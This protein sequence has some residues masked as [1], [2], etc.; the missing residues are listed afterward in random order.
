MRTI[1]VSDTVRVLIT[2]VEN[3]VMSWTARYLLEEGF[4]IRAVVDR[5]VCSDYTTTT[6][7]MEELK[8]KFEGRLETVHT[9][10]VNED[11]LLLNSVMEDCG[12]IIH[13]ADYGNPKTVQEST[14]LMKKLI[15]V[16]HTTPTIKRFI[17]CCSDCCLYNNPKDLS[18]H[19]WTEENFTEDISNNFSAAAEQFAWVYW[20]SLEDISQPS[21]VVADYSVEETVVEIPPLQG[22]PLGATFA[23][24]RLTHVADGEIAS[25]LGFHSHIGKTVVEVNGYKISSFDELAAAVQS[26][27]PFSV[28]LAVVAD[29]SSSLD[30]PNKVNAAPL[31]NPSLKPREPVRPLYTGTRPHFGLTSVIVT[32]VVGPPHCPGMKLSPASVVVAGVLNGLYRVP[33]IGINVVDIRDVCKSLML[34]ILHKVSD[35]RRYV[36]SNQSVLLPEFM[37]L[38]KADVRRFCKNVVSGTMWGITMQANFM[39]LQLPQFQSCL[40]RVKGE[41]SPGYYLSQPIPKKF[42]PFYNHL[43]FYSNDFVRKELGLTL[44]PLTDII[45]DTVLGLVQHNYVE[46][47]SGPP[48]VEEEEDYYYYFS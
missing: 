13:T 43:C 22:R 17:L 45:S 23:D 38:V 48:P 42:L 3:F 1:N 46:D 39:G 31:L 12:Y 37:N 32:D 36:V 28:T 33:N 25:S 15:D 41:S 20:Q 34:C 4:T 8:L 5:K 27:E 30:I 40:K 14:C 7:A 16:A 26:G 24:L 21:T 18:D 11:V 44:T 29:A 47:T 2:N 6:A 9:D 35:A 10:L 19:V